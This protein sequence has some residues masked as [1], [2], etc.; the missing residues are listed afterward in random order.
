M[1]ENETAANPAD[2]GIVTHTELE[3]VSNDAPQ[4]EANTPAEGGENV[5]SLDDLTKEALGDID[6]EATPDLIEVEFDGAK[7]KVDPRVKDALLR[8]ADYTRKTQDLAEQRRAFEAQRADIQQRAQLV[9]QD[10]RTAATIATVEQEIAQLEALD[11]TGW[12]QADIA[13][14]EAQLTQL[15]QY[16]ANLQATLQQRR[17]QEQA[18]GSEQFA[19]ARADCLR[20]AAARVPNF[21]D[22]RRSGLEQFAVSLGATPDDVAAIDQPWAYEVLHLADVGKKFIERQ[23]AAGQ[24]SKAGAGK[25]SINVGG[26]AKPGGSPEDMSPAEYIAWRNAGN[27]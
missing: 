15:R 9:Q 24:M 27:G 6:P 12:S 23:R 1:L 25:P 8:Q 4:T 7:V 22:E 18:Q 14:G 2:G 17:Q 16:N 5:P 11:I 19:K 10:F 13:A 26:N 20:E 21:S 3:P